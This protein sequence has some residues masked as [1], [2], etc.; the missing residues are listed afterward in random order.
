ML[1][2]YANIN[3]I[4]EFCI[5]SNN[6]IYF[7]TTLSEL[8]KINFYKNNF[9]ISLTR[10]NCDEYIAFNNKIWKPHKYSQDSWIFKSPIKEMK[11]KINLGW[12]QCDNIISYQYSNLGYQVINPHYSINAWHLH[13]SNNTIQL[14]D[15]FNYKNKFKMLPVE[16]ESIDDIINRKKQKIEVKKYYKFNIN[17]LKSIKSKVI[18]S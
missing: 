2:K 11:N 1:A 15:K 17:K 14:V 8:Y 3:L 5:I 13:K 4:N 18:N 7:D 6:D 12:I 9:F 10:K 16:L